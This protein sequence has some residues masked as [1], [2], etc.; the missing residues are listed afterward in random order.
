[1]C[2]R[3]SGSPAPVGGWRMDEPALMRLRI[4]PRMI[5]NI[6]MIVML[7]IAFIVVLIF[8]LRNTCPGGAGESPDRQCRPTRESPTRPY[9]RQLASC[10]LALASPP[11]H[12]RCASKPRCSESPQTTTS[13]PPH[14]QASSAVLWCASVKECNGGSRKT[15]AVPFADARATSWPSSETVMSLMTAGVMPRHKV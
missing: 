14:T 12:P 6:I 2:R 15:C 5:I 3:Y 13:L 7:I 11:P 1:M 8:H 9:S 4:S 10:H